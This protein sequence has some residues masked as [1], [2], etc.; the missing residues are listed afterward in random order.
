MTDI[1]LPTDDAPSRID[2]GRQSSPV[3]MFD[4]D[5]DPDDVRT[6]DQKVLAFWDK[7]PEGRIVTD[8]IYQQSGDVVVATARVW[9][10]A[11]DRK[12]TT[13]AHASRSYTDGDLY[14]NRATETAESVAIGRALRFFPGLKH[15]E[16]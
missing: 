9:R 14:A 12:P 6:V 15:E 16:S 8:V 5:Q 11:S 7:Y 3:S 4:P 1:L 13:T 2:R 10:D